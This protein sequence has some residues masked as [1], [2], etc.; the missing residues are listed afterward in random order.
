MRWPGSWHLKASPKLARLVTLNKAAEVHLP[1]AVEALETAAE[2]A[3]LLD[4]DLPRPKTSS[5]PQ[6]PLKLVESALAA[7][8]NAAE[9]WDTW[10]KVGLLVYAAT[11]ASAEGLDAWITWSAKSSKKFVAGAC[12]ERWAH[13]ATSPPTR[14]GAGTL[15]MLAKAA[16]WKRP[17]DTQM[18]HPLGPE[19][20]PG[21]QPAQE[22][23]AASDG[24]DTDAID[25]VIDRFNNK[26]LMVNEAGKA[27][28]YQ[29]GYNSVLK[30]D[31]S[32]GCHQGL[33]DT[34]PQSARPGRSR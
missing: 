2:Q 18:G 3:G 19:D 15:F 26:F 24:A 8:P 21:Y 23:A 1:E 7:L 12:E 34:L 33:T 30:A 20:D 29:P 5:T 32:T 6:A 13:F 31:A 14:G 16:G 4:H 27:I 28:I 11:G 22:A 25:A 10:I 17:I 9:H